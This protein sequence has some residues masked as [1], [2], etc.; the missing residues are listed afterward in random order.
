MGIASKDI[1]GDGLPE[2]VL[3]S[4]GDQLLQLNKGNG[5]MANAPIYWHLRDHPLSG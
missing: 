2:V 3:T 4:M 5:Q 1:T